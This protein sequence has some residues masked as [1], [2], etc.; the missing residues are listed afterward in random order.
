[1]KGEHFKKDQRGFPGG[2]VV[3]IL[4]FHCKGVQVPSL[5]PGQGTMLPHAGEMG[6]IR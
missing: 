2:P 4:R 5:I 3:K 6:G 1:M